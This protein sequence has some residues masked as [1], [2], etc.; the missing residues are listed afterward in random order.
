MVRLLVASVLLAAAGGCVGEDVPEYRPLELDYL[1]QSIFAPTCGSTQCHSSFKQA[2][3]NVFDTP[4]G[5]RA[6]LVNDALV[7]TDP[8]QYDPED[9]KNADLIHWITET[10][11][12]GTEGNRRMPLDAPMPNR[13][14][15]LLIEWIEHKAP[16]A[17][18]NPD[19]D[20][21]K[22]CTIDSSGRSVVA[23][24]NDDWNYDL[25]TAIP[26]TGGCAAGQC[27]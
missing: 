24:C 3:G 15:K 27:I 4:E 21:G 12:F 2:G 17:Q 1:T 23:T 13:D 22:S 10:V 18:C 20:N 6:T 9:A 19:A 14:V 25:S 11:P 7:R 5:V 16:G 8:A 26:C